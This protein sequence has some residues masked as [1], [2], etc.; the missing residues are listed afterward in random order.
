MTARNDR[1]RVLIAGGGGGV[2]LACADVLDACGAEL[3]LCDVDGFGLTQA[4]K[5]LDAFTRYCDAI[6]DNSVAIFAA[7]I[8]QKFPNIDV[9]INAVGRGY[10]RAL[11][12]MRM[13]RAFMPLLRGGSGRRLL[14]NV[15]PAGGFVSNACMF[16]YGSSQRSFHGLAEAIKDQARGTSINVVNV[17]PRLLRGREANGCPSDHLYQ[18]QRVDEQH[19]AERVLTVIEAARGEALRRRP[20]DRGAASQQA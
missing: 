6:D 20:P 16:P 4:G 7:E 18:L 5:R 1:L 2:G 13:T 14:I 17:T 10:V 11:A 3:I 12:M 19:T 9:L 15:A 8:A